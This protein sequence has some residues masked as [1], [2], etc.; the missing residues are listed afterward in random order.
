MSEE[1][2][3]VTNITRYG[4]PFVVGVFYL[5]ASLGFEFTADSTFLVLGAMKDGSSSAASGFPSPLWQFLVMVGGWFHLNS[6]LTSK[7][8]GLVFSCAAI[9]AMYLVANEVLRDGLLAFC[10]ALLLGMQGWLVQLAPSG[11]AVTLAV[12]LTLAGLFFMLRNEYVVTPFILGLCTLVFWQ[13]VFLLIPLWVDIRANSVSKSRSA[14]VTLS[15][16]LMY[17]SAL[18]PWGLYAW[19]NGV[20]GLPVLFRVAEIPQLSLLAITAISFPGL[21]GVVGIALLVLS[22]T[23]GTQ[24]LRVN[25]GVLTFIA[26]IAL[27]GLIYHSD[28]WRVAV[29]LIVMFAFVGLAQILKRFGSEKLLYSLSFVLT[30]LLLVQLQFDYYR[31]NKP[32]MLVANGQ[33]N[34]LQVVAVWLRMNVPPDQLVC[35]D[36]PGILG[37]FAERSVTRLKEQEVSCGDAVVTSRRDVPGYDV[38]FNPGGVPEPTPIAAEHYVVWRRK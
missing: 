15:A 24:T 19:I 12:A 21:L 27:T 8:L 13:A 23:A 10:V 37:Y 17:L 9:F 25:S 26:V 1:Q 33:A 11:S 6:L 32:A 28:V 7:V 29:P 2:S 16:F 38:A 20:S 31:V 4:L 30:G 34:E 3:Y 18:L 35:A 36:R 5:T 22:E 14:K